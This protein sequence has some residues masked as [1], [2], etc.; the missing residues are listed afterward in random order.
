MTIHGIDITD[1]H[2]HNLQA[3]HAIISM[4]QEWIMQPQTFAPRPQALYSAG[5]HPWWTTD[6]ASTALMLQQLPQLL[7]HPQVVALGECGLDALR[8]ANVDEQEQVLTQQL[9]LAEQWHLPVTLHIVRAYDR[10]L[11]LH[12]LL[13]PTTQ[14]TVHGFRGKPALAQQLLQAGMNL[15]FGLKRNDES[16]NITPPHRRFTE[17]D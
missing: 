11:R 14:W 17:T 2:T 10:L 9:L 3:D 6:K 7:S 5:I 12:K 4:P 16:W 13:R 8:G 1:F 15:S